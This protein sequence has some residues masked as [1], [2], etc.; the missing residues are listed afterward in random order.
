LYL[1]WNLSPTY[2]V[3]K[4]PCLLLFDEGTG[5]VEVRDITNGKMCEVLTE[6]CLRA[7]RSTKG[8]GEVLA[9]APGLGGLVEIKETVAL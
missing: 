3:Y 1:K 7:V 2:S 4:A 9:L 5:H 6:K 8:S